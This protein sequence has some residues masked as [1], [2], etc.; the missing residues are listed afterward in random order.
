MSAIQ[1]LRAEWLD[2]IAQRDRV[3]LDRTKTAV[4]YERVFQVGQQALARYQ[5]A[6]ERSSP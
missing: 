6:K 4:D 3:W 2:L 1:Q 5:A